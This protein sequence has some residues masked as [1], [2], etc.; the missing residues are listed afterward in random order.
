LLLDVIHCTPQGASNY[1]FLA[2]QTEQAW[3]LP[4]DQYNKTIHFDLG[5]GSSN[6]TIYGALHCNWWRSEVAE[7]VKVSAVL[8]M[9]ALK[10]S[11]VV[12]CMVQVAG[13]GKHTEIFGLRDNGA[14]F[15][16]NQPGVDKITASRG[17]FGVLA[18]VEIMA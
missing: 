9:Y 3:W 8:D 1:V 4:N 17:W 11:S 10:G 6:V 5:L 13:V 14:K 7:M 2:M 18:D 15:A 16:I 12:C